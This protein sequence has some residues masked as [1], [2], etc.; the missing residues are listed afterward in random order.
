MCCVSFHLPPGVMKPAAKFPHCPV[1]ALLRLARD[2]LLQRYD[3]CAA[4]HVLSVARGISCVLYILLRVC[5]LLPEYIGLVAVLRYLVKISSEEINPS[6]G[7][8]E[9]ALKVHRTVTPD[10]EYKRWQ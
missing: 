6:I 9:N 4:S 8:E 5:L 3:S 10:G 7:K 1:S 2:W